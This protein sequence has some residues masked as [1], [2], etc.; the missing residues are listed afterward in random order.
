MK[1]TLD[2]LITDEEAAWASRDYE[3]AAQFKTERVRLETEYGEAVGKWRD[4]TGLDE[5]V[6]ASDIAQLVHS[7]TGIPVS[8]MLQTEQEKLLDMEEH[9]SKR[10]IGQQQAVVAGS[11]GLPPARRGV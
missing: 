10:I 4:E 8:S 1:S 5:M 7:W 3:N 6:E 11:G 2:K 9:L